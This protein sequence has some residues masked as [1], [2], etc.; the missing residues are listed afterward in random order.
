M[1]SFNNSR[2]ERVETKGP[3]FRACSSRC[4][5]GKGS[6]ALMIFLLR[7]QAA[8]RKAQEEK[9]AKLKKTSQNT[10]AIWRLL[11]RVNR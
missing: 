3:R 8:E 11:E 1:A 10:W 9:R 2:T 6:S 4:T 7:A 5:H